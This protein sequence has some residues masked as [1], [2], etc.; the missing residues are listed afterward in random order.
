MSADVVARGLAVAAGRRTGGAIIDFNQ[1]AAQTIAPGV[2]AVDVLVGPHSATAIADAL[3]T[4][5]LAAA[6]P[7]FCKADASGRLFRLVPIGSAISVE[8][9]GATGTPGVNDQPAIQATIDYA[10]AAGIFEVRFL[11][12]AYELWCPV[13]TSAAHLIT[14]DGTPIGIRH[15]VKLYS[16]NY[17]TLNF[18]GPTGG[19]PDTDFQFVG[20]NPWRGGGV[21]ILGDQYPFPSDPDD[22]TIQSFHM[23]NFRLA[24]G[25]TAGKGLPSTDTSD[26]GVFTH[27]AVHTIRLVN[28]EID[29]FLH[30]LTYGGEAVENV[31]LTDVWAHSSCQSAFNFHNAKRI[32]DVR[33][34]YG[35]SYLAC[36][37]IAN[38]GG[39]EFFGTTFYDA[40]GGGFG[41]RDGTAAPPGADFAYPARGTLIPWTTLHDVRIE[42]VIGTF[43][44]GAYVRGSVALVDT[45]LSLKGAY[46]RDIDL[47]ISATL[48]Q[49]GGVTPL[50]F[51]GA[52]SLE[53]GI[54]AG[55]YPRHINIDL[56]VLRTQVAEEN[57]RRWQYAVV[58]GGYLDPETCFIRIR[59]IESCSHGAV[60]GYGSPIVA[61]PKIVIDQWRPFDDT[62][63]LVAGLNQYRDADFALNGGAYGLTAFPGA[64]AIAVSFADFGVP[65][66]GYANGQ[67]FKF[68]QGGGGGRFTFARNGPN[69]RLSRNLATYRKGDRIDFEYSLALGKWIDVAH[70]TQPPEGSATW[71][72]P[73]IAAGG[74]TSTTVTVPGA[75]LGDFVTG[76]SFGASTSGLTLSAQVTGVD[77]VTVWLAN[78]TAAAVDLPA[79]TVRVRVEKP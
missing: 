23:E 28:V 10:G 71:D 11:Q 72:P 51:A 16:P 26:K 34:R 44:I 2:P 78:P 53:T 76:V 47:R 17:T 61:H 33:G 67:A 62:N 60:D 69:M 27:T 22:L 52:P 37:C 49:Y 29:H 65:G 73:S 1:L 20:G 8:L 63:S 41:G 31:E 4:P 45:Y 42:N 9:G 24:G 15:S 70:Y 39:N 64:P 38:V 30:E 57:N 66:F 18:K 13:R 79:A 12:P 56:T 58:R 6:H 59:N 19:H 5:A 14:T 48:D 68:I 77:T 46:S 25:R 54:L 40:L 75:V 74:R 55:M 32:V 43:E 3:A 36:E 21:H 35:D 7:R 50:V